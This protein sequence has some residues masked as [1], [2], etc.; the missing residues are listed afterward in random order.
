MPTHEACSYH[1][2]WGLVEAVG[3]NLHH[4]LCRNGSEFM[5]AGWY[6]TSVDLA[7]G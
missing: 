7:Q 4:R 5:P 3:V 6:I 1:L 2:G